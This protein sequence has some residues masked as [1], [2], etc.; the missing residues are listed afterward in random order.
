MKFKHKFFII[1]II[2]IILYLWYLLYYKYYKEKFNNIN[3]LINNT[4]IP[5]NIYFCFKHKNIPDYIIPIWKNLNPN[6]NIILYDN[7][8]CINFLNENYGEEYV[9][10][11][12]FIKDG[13]I[14]ADFWRCCIL[15]KYG[16]VYADIDI[17][18]LMSID[19]LLE[20]DLEL[21]T[22]RSAGCEECITPELII[23]K[24]HNKLLDMCIKTYIKYMNEKVQYSYWGWSIVHIMRKNFKL[25]INKDIIKSQ[26]IYFDD[27]NKKY[28]LIDE[29]MDSDDTYNDR[30][31]YNNEIV[32]Y[33]RYK[34]YD[35]NN[36]TF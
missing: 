1:I 6:Y 36:H 24:K 13:P 33:N 7:N 10:I 2:V 4:D 16:G 31:I 9:N 21:L 19:K 22:V 34:E 17:K 29:I 11:F 18:P 12:N 25:L 23:S 5:K 15:F 32:L 14:K 35:N 3:N 8:D 20:E 27:E 28:K 30:V 26:S